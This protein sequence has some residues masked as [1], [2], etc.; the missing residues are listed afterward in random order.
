MDLSK[1]KIGTRL[2]VGFTSIILLLIAMAALG[3]RD[4]AQIEARLEKIVSDNIYKMGLVQDMSES[5]HIVSRVT[6][7]LVLLQDEAQIQEEMKK[8]VAAR[9]LAPI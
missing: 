7:T 6:R 3:M 5:V 4:M 2:A 8:I 9:D 1:F